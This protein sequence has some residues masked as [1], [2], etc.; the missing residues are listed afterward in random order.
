MVGVAAVVMSTE[1]EFSALSKVKRSPHTIEPVA[2]SSAY[3]RP[4]VVA[5]ITKG[6]SP[7]VSA[8]DV[9]TGKGTEAFHLEEPSVVLI[10]CTTPAGVP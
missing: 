3:N 10:A 4:M 1:G 8:T 6:E 9:C 2:A 7:V 5:T